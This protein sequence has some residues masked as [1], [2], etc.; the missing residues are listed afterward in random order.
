M[1]EKANGSIKL[2][3]LRFHEIF[4]FHR[5]ML[6][7]FLFIIITLSLTTSVAFSQQENPEIRRG[8]REYKAE[9]FQE[10][11]LNFRKALEANPQSEKALYNLANA[12][13]K[14]GRYDEAA[15]ILKGLV[16]MD[17][18][19]NKKADVYHNLGNASIGD[20]KIQEGIDAYKNVLRLRPDDNDARQ[21]LA[22]AQKLLQEQE[23]QQ[24]QQQQGEDGP[25][26][27]QQDEQPEQQP[28]DQ[29]EEAQQQERPRPDQISPEDAERILDALNQQEREIQEKIEREEK[30][31]RPLQPE[32]QW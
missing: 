17:L 30:Q 26:D 12:L 5:Q 27:Q 15:N 11:E 10:A 6:K 28:G 2:N 21:N 22:I 24:Q 23:Q 7:Q 14:Q 25:D 16:H 9:N 31:R 4:K 18:P 13:Y 3:F 29:P 19:E 8:V 32:R 1:K 20:Q